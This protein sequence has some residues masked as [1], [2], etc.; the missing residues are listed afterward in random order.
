MKTKQAFNKSSKDT[1]IARYLKETS[2]VDY[3]E[4]YNLDLKELGKSMLASMDKLKELR[5]F[6]RAKP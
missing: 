4:S 1:L 5:G 2:V 3:S 6:N